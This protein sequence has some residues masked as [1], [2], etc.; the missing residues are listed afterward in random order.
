MPFINQVLK[1][2]GG[3][4]AIPNV[5]RW[6]SATYQLTAAMKKVHVDFWKDAL[7]HVRIG[8]DWVD[9]TKHVVE[10]KATEI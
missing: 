1:P 10:V 8:P 2:A 7:F 6:D 4:Q 9:Y 3:W 5:T